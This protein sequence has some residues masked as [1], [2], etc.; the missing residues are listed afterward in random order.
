MSRGDAVFL[1]NPL[2]RCCCCFCA[3]AARTRGKKRRRCRRPGA[4]TGAAC[5]G[6]DG[7]VHSSALDIYL[8]LQWDLTA[9]LSPLTDGC[10]PLSPRLSATGRG[11]SDS[12]LGEA[13]R[14]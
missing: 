2:P 10:K 13:L 11:T 4:G 12:I 6:H 1:P 8:A 9:S 14:G 3:A 5:R 7:E